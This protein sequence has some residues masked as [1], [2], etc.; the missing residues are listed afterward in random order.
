MR[1]D[2]PGNRDKALRV[3]KYLR[4]LHKLGSVNRTNEGNQVLWIA[5]L[6][7]HNSYIECNL[8]RIDWREEEDDRPW[9]KL[10]KPTQKNPAFPSF[11]NNVAFEGKLQTVSSETQKI[12]HVFNNFFGPSP[13]E[14]QLLS[15]SWA[16]VDTDLSLLAQSDSTIPVDSLTRYLQS[17]LYPYLDELKQLFDARRAYQQ[18]YAL[19]H[20]FKKQAEEL[21][22]LLGV[23]LLS[24]APGEGTPISRHLIALS[25]E[26]DF[27]SKTGAIVVDTQNPARKPA[28]E[29]DMLDPTDLGPDKVAEAEKDLAELNSTSRD[30]P[31][32]HEILPRFANTIGGRGNGMYMADVRDEYK[33]RASRIPVVTFSPALILRK[34]SSRAFHNFVQSVIDHPEE[35]L[36]GTTATFSKLSEIYIS[37]KD[38]Q[39]A[40]A[41]FSPEE[42]QTIYFP[43]AYNDEQIEIVHKARTTP[44]VLVLGPPGTGKSHTIANL[45]CH[46][47]AEG[48]RI[49]ITSQSPRALQV[50]HGMLPKEIQPLCIQVLGQDA[51][52]QTVLERCVGGIL[53]K[54]AKWKDAVQD[55]KIAALRKELHE[56]RSKLA[57]LKNREREIRVKEIEPLSTGYERYSGKM[58]QIA[59]AA[60]QDSA[61]FSWFTDS[62]T[63]GECQLS[64]LENHSRAI[65]LLKNHSSKRA[66]SHINLSDLIKKAKEAIQLLERKK[67]LTAAIA[68]LDSEKAQK[69]ASGLGM[70]KADELRQIDQE[71]TQVAELVRQFRNQ[72]LCVC[73]KAAIEIATDETGSRWLQFFDPISE[74]IDTLEE[75][76]QKAIESSPTGSSLKDICD[77]F[78]N[79][80]DL[81]RHREA[82]GGMSVFSSKPEPVKLALKQLKTRRP[83]LAKATVDELKTTVRSLAPIDLLSQCIAL[84]ELRI[85]EAATDLSLQ[86]K[87]YLQEIKKAK[88]CL[89]L[90]QL[91]TKLCPVLS[92]NRKG[93][94]DWKSHDAIINCQKGVKLKFVQLMSNDV[95]RRLIEVSQAFENSVIRYADYAPV[96]EALRAINNGDLDLLKKLHLRFEQDNNL[97]EKIRSADLRFK[98]LREHYPSLY[99]AISADIQNPLWP[100][101]ILQLPEACRWKYAHTKIADY[102]STQKT[103]TLK[104]EFAACEGR[105]AE[106]VSELASLLAWKHCFKRMEDPE[107]A[108]LREWVDAMK[109]ARMKYSKF[110]LRYRAEAQAKM[111]SCRACVPA[112]V[113]PLHRVFETVPPQPGAFEVIIVD[114]ASQCGQDASLLLWL[115]KQVIVVGDDQQI[116][117]TP[118]GTDKTQVFNLMDTYLKDFEHKTT[119]YPESSLFDHCKVLFPRPVS[120]REHFRCMPEIIRFSNDLCYSASPLI[121]L[122]SYPTDRLEPLVPV[123]VKN[124]YAEG[125]NDTIINRNE[126][127][128]IVEQIQKCIADRRY[129][130]KTFG[131]IALQGQGQAK[132]I[133]QMVLERLNP[134]EIERRRLI[135]GSPYSFQGDQRHIIFMSMIVAVSDDRRRPSALVQDM[136][137]KRFNVAASR[138]QDQVFLFHS[139]GI[140]EL[141]PDCLRRRLLEHYYKRPTSGPVGG[142]ESLDELVKLASRADRKIERPPGEFDSW[143]EVDVFLHLRTKEYRVIE[144][145]PINEYRIDMVIE[146]EKNKLALE[147]DGDYWHGPDQWEADKMRQRMLERSGWKFYRLLESEYRWNPETA[148]EKLKIELEDNN[149]LPLYSWPKASNES[150]FTDQTGIDDE[151][152][153][154]ELAEDEE[155]GERAAEESPQSDRDPVKPIS[156]PQTSHFNKQQPEKKFSAKETC[157][158][159]VVPLVTDVEVLIIKR[160]IYKTLNSESSA[161]LAKEKLCEMIRDG[162]PSIANFYDKFNKAI[163]L[164]RDRKQIIED[165]SGVVFL[166]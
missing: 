67:K 115:G 40:I 156:R 106:I 143:F 166:K 98:N 87:L 113:M 86:V 34:R 66:I 49:L 95:A 99:D 52:E 133:T 47:L 85:P 43:L 83:N 151:E 3:F 112:W 84:F 92:D 131:V 147:C 61:R 27:N 4:D 78:R 148:F 51:S 62:V 150:E 31:K 160:H 17:S 141:S 36:T 149:I 16:N 74:K 122:R 164:L 96:A 19:Y 9:L 71:L 162:H 157:E 23:G 163:D 58:A 91:I 35:K 161:S 15:L 50:L 136:F 118:V 39:E 137:K 54:D 144:Q 135:C 72:N 48:K 110:I 139:V 134:A 6:P 82:G 108:N 127:T 65:E 129:A 5:R 38:R 13:S 152:A 1:I 89:S 93:G 21:E 104:R 146:G 63:L 68:A 60:N 101:R 37:E 2:D 20:D 33:E 12:F 18:V 88:A 81:I 7:E 158:T 111:D 69:V 70:I 56:R 25:A 123:L 103:D 80:Q 138:G 32:L 41:S 126:A 120:L 128:A 22:L 10:R 53:E 124:G 132:L 11:P 55:K 42:D 79:I 73:G 90:C 64:D 130:G 45:I 105:I 145:F 24:W 59:T 125:K 119:F 159:I 100:G 29:T 109:R 142:C 102:L 57:E 97:F 165:D 26:I 155:S 107:R 140:E 121:P 46:N 30:I 117:P 28:V 76:V 114:E 14:D 116:S 44:G 154:E 153:A 8:W 77:D 94:V 75:E